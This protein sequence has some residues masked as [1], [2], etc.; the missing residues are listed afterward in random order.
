MHS[1]K[2]FQ[3]SRALDLTEKMNCGRLKK[4]GK[5]FSPLATSVAIIAIIL[6]VSVVVAVL[7]E[8]MTIGILGSKE[9]I[10]IINVGYPDANTI[11]V[12]I[13][14]SGGTQATITKALVNGKGITTFAS[15]VAPKNDTTTLTL[16]PCGN[17]SS[18]VLGACYTV[19]LITEKGNLIVSAP[20]I[21]S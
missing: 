11:K 19:S 15:A 17:D 8:G 4:D 18:L 16:N 10:S 20:T 3:L 7:A 2:N 9:Q 14:N 1:S 13:L 5:A 21:Y 12:T 6:A